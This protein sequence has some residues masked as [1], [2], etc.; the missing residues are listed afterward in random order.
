MG[1]LIVGIDIGTTAVKVVLFTGRHELIDTH[2]TEHPM[3]HGK[4][5]WAEQDPR[6]WWQ[7]CLRGIDAVT[8]GAAAGAVG[9]V[10]VTSQVNTHVFVDARLRPLLPAITWQD[11]RCAEIARELNRTVTAERRNEIWGRPYAFD[12]SGL[13]PRALWVARNAPDTWRA[14]RWVL[15]PKDYVNALLTGEIAS[16]A[17]SSIGLVDT[18]GIGYLDAAVAL[19]DGLGDRLPPLARPTDTVG[20][21]GLPTLAC[22]AAVGTMDALSE[23]YAAGLTTPG[24]G[25]I[26]CGTSL[27]V[28]GAAEL[29]IPAKGIVTFPP[30]DGLRIHAGPTQAGGDALRWWA[31]ASG[32][33][34]QQVLADAAAVPPG[35]SGV[36]FTP[37]LMGERAPLWDPDVRGGFLGLSTATTHAELSRAVLEGVAMSGR[38]VLAEVESACGKPLDPITFSGGGANSELWAQIF[39]DVLGRPLHRLASRDYSAVLGAALFGAGIRPD[40]TAPSIDRIFTPDPVHTRRLDPL[41]E[42]YQDTYPA[43]R[44]VHAKLE[45]WRSATS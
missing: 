44:E 37:H 23:M 12:A 30:V 43:L 41:F 15:S 4:P 2:V 10:G 19:V 40:R 22:D 32:Q 5:G 45:K 35:G 18:D 25:M 27:V 24:R 42:I 3:T 11:Q 16:D 8:A 34:I 9:A 36:V 6:D 33:P 31:R 26:S 29:S 14:T 1:E 20:R 39:A 17:M 7:G 28:A 38:Q 13:I 21:I